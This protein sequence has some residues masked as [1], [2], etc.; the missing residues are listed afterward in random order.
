MM[1]HGSAPK[2]KASQ[3]MP[4]TGRVVGRARQCALHARNNANKVEHSA[5]KNIAARALCIYTKGLKHLQKTCAHG[6][7]PQST[8][9][10][11]HSALP[12]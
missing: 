3:R 6:H 1:V 9:W 2:I 10:H 4:H 5:K 8:M 11:T 7:T 12:L